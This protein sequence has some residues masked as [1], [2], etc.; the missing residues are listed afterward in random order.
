MDSSLPGSSVHGI[1]QARVLEWAAISFSRGSS[2]PRD[3]TQ[4]SCIADTLP[5]EPP[6][7]PSLI[8]GN[9]KPESS[10]REVSWIEDSYSISCHPHLH[11]LITIR[12]ELWLTFSHNNTRFEAWVSHFIQNWVI[13]ISQLSLL[14][15]WAER[16]LLLLLS[17]FSRVRLC[18][19]PLMEAHQ[20]PLSLG[21]RIEDIPKKIDEYI[22]ANW[23]QWHIFRWRINTRLLIGRYSSMILKLH[24]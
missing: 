23:M 18:A 17:R 4:V 5:S 19:T 13:K 15:P 16:G 6:G 8:K 2:Q 7:K 9:C 11:P 1:F 20:A 10:W 24:E 14:G 21:K 22:I 3:R 12:S